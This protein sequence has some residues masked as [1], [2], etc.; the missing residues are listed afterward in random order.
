MYP[1]SASSQTPLAETGFN[2]RITSGVSR[3]TVRISAVGGSQAPQMSTYPNGDRVY[4]VEAAFGDD[5]GGSDYSYSDDGVV[6]T[7]AQGRI[8]E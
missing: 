3:F 7:D 4:F 5:S 1:G 6:V 2:L 8:V